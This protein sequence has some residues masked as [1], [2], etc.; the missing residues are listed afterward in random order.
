MGKNS[1]E[2][3]PRRVTLGRLS[4][5]VTRL[6]KRVE[7]LEDLRDLNE[8]IARNKGKPGTPWEQTRKELG[9]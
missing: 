1:Q 6:R 5:E 8:A 7:D 2:A 9:L 4:A 3:K